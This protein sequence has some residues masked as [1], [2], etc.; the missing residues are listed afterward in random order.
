MTKKTFEDSLEKLE[1][2]THDLE[3]GDLSLEASLKKF[4][5]GMKLA[6]FCNKKLDDAQKKINII[7]DKEGVPTPTP[8]DF[9]KSE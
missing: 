2:I 7:M 6:E 9:E 3:E 1:D 4:D 5:E 8:F